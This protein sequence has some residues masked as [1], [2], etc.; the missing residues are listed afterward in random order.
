MFTFSPF[1]IHPEEHR[2]P[3][4]GLRPSRAGVYRKYRVI[5]VRSFRQPAAEFQTVKPIGKLRKF[6]LKMFKRL[7]IVRPGDAYYILNV[8]EFARYLKEGIGYGLKVF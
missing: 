7:I 3:I 6:I 1:E 4:A 5:S 2:R 8:F